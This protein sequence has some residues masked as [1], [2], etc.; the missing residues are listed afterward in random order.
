MAQKKITIEFTSDQRGDAILAL[1]IG[2]ILGDLSDF[3]AEL[4]Q[5]TKYSENVPEA[6]QKIYE[7]FCADFG[8]Y[9]EIRELYNG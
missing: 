8:Q 6:V 3:E 9:L 5:K 2:S 1:M 4:R 7:N